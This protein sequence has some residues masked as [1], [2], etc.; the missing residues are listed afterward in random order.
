MNRNRRSMGT[1]KTD[2]KAQRTSSTGFGGPPSTNKKSKLPKPAST[3][4]SSSSRGRSGSMDRPRGS[5]VSAAFG[6]FKTPRYFTNLDSLN[7]INTGSHVSL[8]V[9]LILAICLA[10]SNRAMVVSFR[11]FVNFR[12]MN[13]TL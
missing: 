4:K 5:A 2:W 1:V 7:S 10:H 11:S 8:L 6:E 13:P 12:L 9:S 3:S